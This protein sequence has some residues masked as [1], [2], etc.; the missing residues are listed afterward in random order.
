MAWTWIIPITTDLSRPKSCE[1]FIFVRSRNANTDLKPFFEREAIWVTWQSDVQVYFTEQLIKIVNQTSY[2]NRLKIA[3][4]TDM[5]QI[6]PNR[7]PWMLCLK[8]L[9]IVVPRV[10]VQ[11]MRFDTPTLIIIAKAD[12][13]T[14]WQHGTSV[15]ANDSVRLSHYPCEIK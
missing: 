4:E 2:F 5:Y 10:D 14:Q 9:K 6:H 12:I 11:G 8:A 15:A 13:Y 1:N 3:I 7:F